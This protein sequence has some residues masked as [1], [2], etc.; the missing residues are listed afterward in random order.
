MFYHEHSD[1][2][3]FHYASDHELDREEA[4]I[5]GAQSPHRAWIATDRDVWHRN[6][7]YNGPDVPHPEDYDESEEKGSEP[8]N[9]DL[10]DEIPF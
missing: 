10:D 1:D 2:Q 7:Y 9:F 5:L 3:D 8:C 6:P 4:R